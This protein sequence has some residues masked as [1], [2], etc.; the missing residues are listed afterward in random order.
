[1]NTTKYTRGQKLWV[2]IYSTWYKAIYIGSGMAKVT[3]WTSNYSHIAIEECSVRKRE[4][5]L[6]LSEIL[7]LI[8]E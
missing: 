3:D 7:S 6:A 8:F 2:K 4:D 5:D 1:M